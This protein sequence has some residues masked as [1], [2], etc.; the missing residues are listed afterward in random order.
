MEK[1][2]ERIEN[3]VNK[4]EKDSDEVN[5][6]ITKHDLRLIRDSLVMYNTITE[7]SFDILNKYY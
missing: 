5:I 6:K 4:L 1:I 7:K 3:E 2:I